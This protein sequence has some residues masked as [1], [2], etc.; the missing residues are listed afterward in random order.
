[1]GSRRS[2][3]VQSL[4]RAGPASVLVSRVSPA[5]AGP[6]SPASSVPGTPSRC[7]VSIHRT[8]FF[9]LGHPAAGRT[10]WMMYR[11]MHGMMKNIQM[12]IL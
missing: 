12:P 10:Q 1:M 7:S 8:A 11:A 5:P 4:G 6:R 3:L 9:P 2:G